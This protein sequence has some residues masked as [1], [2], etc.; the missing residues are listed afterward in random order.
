VTIHSDAQA[1]I[2]GVGHTGTGPGQDRAIRVVKAVKDRLTQGWKTCIEWV[3]GH[4]GIAGNERPDQV[5]GEAAAEKHKGR[6]SIAWL[7]ERI[8]QHYTMAKD[9]EVEKGKHSI[10]PPAPKQSFL[11]SAPNRI[12][13]T[14]AQIRTGHWLRAPYLKRVRKNRDE[15]I[16]DKCWWCGKFR[17]SRTHIFLRCTHP[18]LEQARKDIWDRPDEEGIIMKRPTSVGQ[19]LGKSK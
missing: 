10:I 2:A 19:L 8:S 5:A 7:K 11:D 18:K 16:S 17:M 3:P 1:A 9:T 12:S 4:T 13:R 14:I 15:E 6:T